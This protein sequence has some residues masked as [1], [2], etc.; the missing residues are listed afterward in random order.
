MVFK[1]DKKGGGWHER[2]YTLE[3]EMEFY[4]R[5]NAGPI[6]I[7]RAR[8]LAPHDK[9]EPEQQPPPTTHCIDRDGRCGPPDLIIQDELQSQSA[10]GQL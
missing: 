2:P 4:R 6:T 3:E 10:L 9:P 1:R 5:M 8:G 7:Y